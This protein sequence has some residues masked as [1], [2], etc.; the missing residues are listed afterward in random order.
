MAA[1]V[2]RRA[3]GTA[4]ENNEKARDAQLV[5]GHPIMWVI[6]N[7]IFTTHFP[8]NGKHIP[9]IKMVIFFWGC[10]ILVVLPTSP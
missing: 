6:Q 3:G 9:A 2:D 8:G 7:A 4:L 5:P 10:W 1:V